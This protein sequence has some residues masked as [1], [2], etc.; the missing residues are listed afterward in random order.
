M[1]VANRVSKKT[2]IEE[3]SEMPSIPRQRVK[4]RLTTYTQEESNNKVNESTYS[5]TKTE[6]LREVKEYET[7]T[8]D[9]AHKQI[10]EPES[11]SDR[12][13]NNK[14]SSSKTGEYSLP[15]SVALVEGN[16]DPR[17]FGKVVKIRR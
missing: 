5:D 16:Y 4:L 13:T 2:E 17:N 15:E 8:E 7:Y 9:E 6:P 12:I 1:S 3:E 10:N 14:P 11:V